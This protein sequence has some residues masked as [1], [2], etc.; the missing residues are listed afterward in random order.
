MK[1]NLALKREGKY[2][3]KRL[4]KKEIK[5]LVIK[6][7]REAGWAPI[8]VLIFHW[9]AAHIGVLGKLDWLMHFLG[10]FSMAFFLYRSVVNGAYFLGELKSLTIYLF[11]F[12]L[13][14]CVAVFWEFGEWAS[15]I[16]LHTHVQKSISETMKDLLFGLLGA[17]LLLV[18]VCAFSL[19]RRK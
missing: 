7:M 17:G 19:F 8:G 10:G 13:T 4:M 15:D 11:S 6:V 5:V 1:G 2:Q 3:R 18:F 12:S 14:C 9:Y 16:F